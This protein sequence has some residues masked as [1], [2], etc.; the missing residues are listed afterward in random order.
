LIFLGN[1]I[2]I[3]KHT[4]YSTKGFEGALEYVHIRKGDN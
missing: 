1:K 4:F 3:I 2:Y